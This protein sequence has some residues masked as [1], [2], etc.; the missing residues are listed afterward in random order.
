MKREDY[1]AIPTDYPSRIVHLRVQLGLP[2]TRLAEL[3]Q[4]TTATINRWEN[5]Q[6]KPS[7]TTWQRLMRAERL[8]ADALHADYIETR[9]LRE[10][11]P[12]Y[13][14]RPPLDFGGNPEAIR[15]VI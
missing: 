15:L 3:L 8:G 11:G 5:G 1:E 12:V 7:P 13:T 6:S 4:V 10:T 9:T 14:T 2:Q